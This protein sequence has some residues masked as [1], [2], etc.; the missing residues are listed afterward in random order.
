MFRTTQVRKLLRCFLVLI[1]HLGMGFHKLKPSETVL[2]KVAGPASPS[3]NEQTA[4]AKI[5]K[6]E[7]SEGDQV[8]ISL[9]LGHYYFVYP[10]QWALKLRNG[11]SLHIGKSP[12][13]I[14]IPLLE[15]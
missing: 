9:K 8:L 12:A 5:S 6:K 2:L 11:S 4:S 3:S 10:M 13:N 15:A 1:F 7:F 14:H